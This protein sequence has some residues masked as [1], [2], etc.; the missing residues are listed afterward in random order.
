MKKGEIF[1]SA[2]CI[3]FFSFMFYQ[4]YLLHGVGRFGEM[5]SGFWP[6][7]FLGV[8]IA[9]SGG[10]F[11]KSL[12]A[13][14]RSGSP[15]RPSAEEAAAAYARRRK[16]GLSILCLFAYILAMPWIGFAAATFL[17]VLFFVL[18]LEE[19]R[20]AV[21]ILSPFLVTAIVILVF[22]K[23]VAI[24]FPKGVGIFAEFSRLFY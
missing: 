1:V 14:R 16:V 19:R 22:A 15:P 3:V 9:L 5:G 23:F 18:S 20:K 8:S 10:W 6:M 4:A 11:V 7:L 21:L 13:V 17:F 2:F 24:A 12:L